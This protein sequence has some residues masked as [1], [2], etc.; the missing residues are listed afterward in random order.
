MDQSEPFMRDSRY[1]WD[2]KDGLPPLLSCKPT[3]LYA[4]SFSLPNKG[5]P[6]YRVSVPL[7][8]KPQ[9]QNPPPT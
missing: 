5:A 2:Y 4:L 9:K 8:T 1:G 7:Q 6:P 3:L